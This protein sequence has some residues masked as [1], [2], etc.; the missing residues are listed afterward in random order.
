MPFIGYFYC[1]LLKF[2]IN[3]L[4]AGWR[5]GI[6]GIVVFSESCFVHAVGDP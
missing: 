2:I 4:T 3:K 6:F 1:N 5:S